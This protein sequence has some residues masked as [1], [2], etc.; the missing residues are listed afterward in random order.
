MVSYQQINYS[1]DFKNIRIFLKPNFFQE[2]QL[3]Q[4]ELAKLS[5][6]EGAHHGQSTSVNVKAG[7]F[8]GSKFTGL[9]G[10][11]RT[12]F[13]NTVLESTFYPERTDG[14]VERLSTLMKSHV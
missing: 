1:K 12:K 6:T 3:T 5:G 8:G 11:E 14:E 2:A 4:A 10:E 13:V 9:K 7:S